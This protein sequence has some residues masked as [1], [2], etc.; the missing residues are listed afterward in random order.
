[1]VDINTSGSKKHI[2]DEIC[3]LERPDLWISALT[4][5]ALILPDGDIAGLLL[6][7]NGT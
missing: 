2:Y 3:G 4:R 1:M 6:K 5:P 7:G